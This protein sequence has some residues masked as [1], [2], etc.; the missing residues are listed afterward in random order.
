MR[1]HAWVF[2]HPFAAVTG[3]DGTFEIRNVPTGVDLH[4]LAWHEAVGYLSGKDGE[5]TRF[6]A[7]ENVKNYK[8]RARRDQ[9]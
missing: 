9:P 1:A 2:D 5:R 6:R 4:V 8:L 7:G 3:K